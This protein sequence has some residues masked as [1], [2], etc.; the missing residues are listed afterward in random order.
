VSRQTGEQATAEQAEQ[1]SE[2]SSAAE[3]GDQGEQGSQ[4]ES[5]EGGQSGSPEASPPAGPEEQARQRVEQAQQRMREAAERLRDD[6]RPEA[7]VQQREAE[8]E[9]QEA[10]EQL[11]QILRQMR[12]EE[13]ERSLVQLEVRL[14]RMLQIQLAVRGASRELAESR[15]AER[16]RQIEVR[17]GQLAKEEQKVRVEGERA[18][19]LL[20]EEGSS[21]AFPE[22]LEQLLVDVQQTIE[23]LAAADLGPVTLAVQDDIV[24]GLEEM[25]EALS[26][27]QRERE[28]KRQQEEAGQ[29]P[30]NMGDG[31]EEPL[32]GALAE[33]RLIRTLQMR[34]NRRTQTLAQQ[35][36]D[37][38]DPIG[39]F[40]QP[41]QA[42]QLREL[43]V[44]QQKI[45]QVVRDILAMLAEER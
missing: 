28:E 13:V 44:R 26:E 10:V 37:P 7:I 1:G 24:A 20:E 23:R 35:L 5:S 14:Q 22:A 38:S 17:S 33:L 40:N 8:R 2:S 27:A 6:Q 29:A 42:Q 25:L 12:E 31:G 18:L 9:L 11:E 39:Q 4:G 16:E 19:L 30:Q 45:Q 21:V 32:V 34:V 43:G 36:A 3:R 41:Q 15:S